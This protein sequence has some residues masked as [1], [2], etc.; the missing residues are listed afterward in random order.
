[1]TTPR[2]EIARLIERLKA[3]EG[4]NFET[5]A[6][7]NG[8]RDEAAAYLAA[9][10]ARVKELEAEQD[11]ALCRVEEL[12][13]NAEVV[14]DEFEKDCWKAMRSLLSE[15]KFD[16][17][18]VE[19]D[20]VTADEAREYIHDTLNDLETR[21]TRLQQE[22]DEAV[23]ALKSF[24][25]Y[26]LKMV[27]CAGSVTKRDQEGFSWVAGLD[28][29]QPEFRHFDVARDIVRRLASGPEKEKKE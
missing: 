22:R 17:R 15:C 9:L 21:A 6:C 2:D 8:T 7:Y 20:G 5:T 25:K 1:M 16:W 27:A 14:S 29:D 19:H 4:R 12:E 3:Y 28:G 10:S 24:A 11:D 13:R 26:K 18:D 23:S